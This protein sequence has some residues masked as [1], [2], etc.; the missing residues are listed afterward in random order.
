MRVVNDQS[1]GNNRQSSKAWNASQGDSGKPFEVLIEARK[2]SSSS[3]IHFSGATKKVII[4]SLR[5]FIDPSSSSFVFLLNLSLEKTK[6]SFY[7][8]TFRGQNGDEDMILLLAYVC[9][10]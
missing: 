2:L 1:G 5:S 7:G 9:L 4:R 3:E 8:K 6:L 10:E